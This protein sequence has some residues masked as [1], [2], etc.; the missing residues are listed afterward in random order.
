MPGKCK[1]R[2]EV[3]FEARPVFVV[4][5]QTDACM[6][7][8]AALFGDSLEPRDGCSASSVALLEPSS[9]P[10]IC[11]DTAGLNLGNAPF[12]SP[13]ELPRPVLRQLQA[14]IQIASTKILEFQASSHLKAYEPKAGPLA[15]TSPKE[16]RTQYGQDHYFSHPSEI[17]AQQSDMSGSNA[18]QP[19]PHLG[20]CRST[21]HVERRS[22][23]SAESTVAE[24]RY[25]QLQNT[26]SVLELS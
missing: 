20:R 3:V 17:E 2:C 16:S 5:P 25:L 18:W 22:M 9:E 21:A 10:A 6:S 19:L 24:P 23:Q 15:T 14:A 12:M 13:F 26:T 7:L 1:C 8:F 11:W 4:E